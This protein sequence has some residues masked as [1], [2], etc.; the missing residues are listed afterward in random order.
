MS[1]PRPK[2]PFSISRPVSAPTKWH[3]YL[4]ADGNETSALD[5]ARSALVLAL[6]YNLSIE[7]KRVRDCG[8]TSKVA[9]NVAHFDRHLTEN[10]QKKL[11]LLLPL[12]TPLYLGLSRSGFSEI[13]FCF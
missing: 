10:Q 9:A 6:E 8:S 11:N 1:E 7:Q 2:I 12:Q 3:S 5:V 4:R 13:S